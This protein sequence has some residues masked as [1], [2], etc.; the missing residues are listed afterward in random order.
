MDPEG[1]ISTEIRHKF[2]M[3]SYVKSNKTNSR[4]R[5]LVPRGGRW[6]GEWVKVVKRY[7][8]FHDDYS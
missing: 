7:K 5:L 3:I 4:V 1:I 6:D 2:S 8:K